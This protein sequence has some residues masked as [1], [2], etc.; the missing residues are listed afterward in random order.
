MQTM[1]ALRKAEAELE[2]LRGELLLKERELQDLRNVVAHLEREQ[3]GLQEKLRFI[4]KICE[5]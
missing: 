5:T 2:K 4:A 1:L 3:T